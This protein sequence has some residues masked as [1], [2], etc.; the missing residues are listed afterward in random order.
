MSHTSVW[1]SRAIFPLFPSP[2]CLKNGTTL[3]PSKDPGVLWLLDKFET[4]FLPGFI[5]QPFG[6]KSGNTSLLLASIPALFVVIHFYSRQT[7]ITCHF[8]K[9]YS[10]NDL[11]SVGNLADPLVGTRNGPRKQTPWTKTLGLAHHIFE[12]Y[13]DNLFAGAVRNWVGVTLGIL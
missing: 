4:L 13:W 7:F 8:V 6:I 2:F 1:S 11:F 10:S 3:T 5:P 12:A 9:K